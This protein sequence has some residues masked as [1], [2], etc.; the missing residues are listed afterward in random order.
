MKTRIEL[1]NNAVLSGNLSMMNEYT[2]TIRVNNI[3]AN[4]M[5]QLYAQRISVTKL[6]NN[7]SVCV[8]RNKIVGINIWED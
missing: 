2:I 8:D 6:S 1:Q 5:Q 3:D 4:T 7:W